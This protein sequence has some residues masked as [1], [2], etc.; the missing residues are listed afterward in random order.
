MLRHWLCIIHSIK[1]SSSDD[2]MQWVMRD[3]QNQAK[4]IG[5]DVTKEA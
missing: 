4:R 3:E 1:F 2:M 5:A